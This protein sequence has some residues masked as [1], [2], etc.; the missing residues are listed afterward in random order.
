MDENPEKCAIR[1]INQRILPLLIAG[2]FFA[3]LDRANIGFAAMTMNG[4][5]NLSPEVYGFAA[6]IFFIGYV[7]FEVPSNLILNRVG[8]R[9]WLARIMITWGVISAATAFVWSGPSL[10]VARFLL[11]VAEAGY[12]PGVIF[13][14]MAWLPNRYRARFIGTLLAI[15]VA[16]VVIG[17][18]L[19]GLIMSIGSVAGLKNWQWLFL[20][21]GLPSV[22]VGIA[23]LIWL[24]NS[25]KQVAWLTP[26]EKAW[27]EQTLADEQA[28]K[29]AARRYS[30]REALLSP[31]VWLIG[32]A[33]FPNG[34]AGYG[35]MAW[36]PQVAQG[37][38]LSS[39][40]TGLVSALPFAITIVVML[41]WSSHSDRTGERPWHICLP[42]AWAA[43]GLLV[44]AANPPGLLAYL[45][46]ILAVS[47][48][49]SSLVI[50]FTLAPAFLS[51]AAAAA[52]TALVTAIGNIGSFTG[53]YMIGWIKGAGGSHQT[54]LA[55]LA[56]MMG[57]A[58]ILSLVLK[59]PATKA[60]GRMPASIPPQAPISVQES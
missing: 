12:F 48:L 31:K 16:S 1:K 3:Y 54:S 25:P 35:L 51:G 49:F 36:L 45:G 6:G 26:K 27:L 8:A 32:L 9:L 37:F 23:L 44:A 60:G 21:E 41:L 38:G 17:S 30:V 52:G 33:I 28:I 50:L 58:A 42:A 24:P 43:A 13:Y 19:S 29:E 46:I 5:L 56:A 39:I 4:D 34:A 55:V 40:E 57:A 20:I 47:G 2:Y 14:L 15:G 59:P 7:L 53:P 22:L 18:P 10:T 11:G